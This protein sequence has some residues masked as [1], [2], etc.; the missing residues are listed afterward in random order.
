MNTCP[1]LIPSQLGNLVVL[2]KLDLSCNNLSGETNVY[3][4]GFVDVYCVC[5]DVRGLFDSE[6]Y[7]GKT[8]S[9]IPKRPASFD[10]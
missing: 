2:L 4:S 9:R 6:I 8:K 5:H 7:G 1:G 10:S 3:I